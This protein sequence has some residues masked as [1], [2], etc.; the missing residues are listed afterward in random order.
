VL[1][2]TV[3]DPTR[4]AATGGPVTI[5]TY[6]VVVIGAGA[7]GENV[8]DYARQRGCSVVIVEAELVGGECSYWACMPSKALLRPAELLAAARRAPGAAAAVTGDLDVDEVLASRDAAASH[9]E[10]DAQVAWLDGVDVDLVRGRGRLI[11]ERSVQVTTADGTTRTFEATRGVVI[12]TGSRPSV[13]PVDGLADVGAWDSRDATSMRLVPARLLVLGGGVVG[14]EMAQA[15]RRLGAIEVTIVQRGDRVLAREEPFAGEELAAALRREGI[16]VELGVSAVRASR[17]A[18]SGPVTL[19]LEDGR[20]LTA[21]ELLVA[22]GREARTDQLGLEHVG[23]TPDERGFVAVD[24]HLVVPGV[25][26]LSVVGDANGRA[27]FTHQGKYQARLV[28]D[29]LAGV[30]TDAAWADARALPRV[31]FTDPQ[32]AAVGPTL[33]TLRADG[34]DVVAVRHDVG[35]TAGGSLAGE[36]AGGTAQLVIDRERRTVVAATFVGAGVGE[37][38]HAATIAVVGE[39][40]VDRLWH[41]VPVFPTVS[42]VWLRLLERFRAIELEGPDAG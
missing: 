6:D 15:A 7:A 18:A 38:L 26:W 21:D 2:P 32:V 16:E 40:P 24:D 3:P 28:G 34:R 37:L 27:L 25:P 29:R 41:A 36:G 4:P 22:V 30:T 13:P 11:G 39:V 19:E 9:W 14:V 23:V 31:T 42:E 12:A 5:E 10:D 33:E 35:R 8:A 1:D 20:T 17:G